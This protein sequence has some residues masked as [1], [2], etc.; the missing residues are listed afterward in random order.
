MTRLR[1]MHLFLL[2][3]F[4]CLSNIIMCHIEADCLC[5]FGFGGF[6][7]CVIS[8]RVSNELGKGHPVAAKYAAYVTIFQSL[9][10][11]LFCMVVILLSKDHFAVIFTSSK[12][13]QRAVSKLAFLLSV[14]M[15]FNS[16]Q[17]VISGL[18]N[19][20]NFFGFLSSLSYNLD[21]FYNSD[22]ACISFLQV[23]PLEA[24]GKERWLTSTWFV[25]MSL[26]YHLHAFLV[27]Y[28]SWEW[29]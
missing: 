12:D 15:V 17:P 25:T 2:S 3:Q 11:G 26:G 9:L 19:M 14:T 1:T 22:V 5:F 10:I 7:F 29:R 24:D 6:L 18:A 13:V 21:C 23:L 4:P 20:C 8:V 28:S 27:T 16:V